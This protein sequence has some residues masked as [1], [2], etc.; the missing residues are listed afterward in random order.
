[1]E[2]RCNVMIGILSDAAKTDD[3][4]KQAKAVIDKVSK[5]DL[6]RDSI[7]T[8]TTTQAIIKMLQKL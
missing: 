2:K 1:M 7:R 8:I 6:S 3:L 4:F 5:G